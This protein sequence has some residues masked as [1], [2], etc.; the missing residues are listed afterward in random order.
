[1]FRGRHGTGSHANQRRLARPET[2]GA[3]ASTDDQVA[4]LHEQRSGLRNAADA[5]RQSILE[6]RRCAAALARERKHAGRH[7][8][9]VFRAQDE[10]VTRLAADKD[11]ARL[12]NPRI[13]AAAGAR[14]RLQ[15]EA[16]VVVGIGRDVALA[17]QPARRPRQIVFCVENSEDGNLGMAVE[18]AG[19]RGAGDRG[20]AVERTRRAA[21]D[22]RRRYRRRRQVAAIAR[23][24]GPARENPRGQEIPERL[25]C[26]LRIG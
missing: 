3:R 13:S 6:Q 10:S 21:E 26:V 11:F 12:R 7:R 9:S 14:E 19:A 16:G 4:G 25:L 1:M 18:P 17:D 24:I 23:D 8:R 5:V 15:N 2:A 22:R 20:E